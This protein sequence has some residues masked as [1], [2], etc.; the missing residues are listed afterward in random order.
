MILMFRLRTLLVIVTL[1]AF[2]LAIVVYSYRRGN[3]AG[4]QRGYS[5]ALNLRFSDSM[6]LTV[7][8]EI[9]DVIRKRGHGDVAGAAESLAKDIKTNVKPETWGYVGGYGEIVVERNEW[10]EWVLGISN[11]V[12]A[13]IEIS[14]FL[15]D[16]RGAAPGIRDRSYVSEFYENSDDTVKSEQ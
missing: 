16:I 15:D 12:N 9:N 8:Y 6:L 11:S 7:E 13:H 5:S 1:V 14:R 2:M 4:Y 3:D 10:S